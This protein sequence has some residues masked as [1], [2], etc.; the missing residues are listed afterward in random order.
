MTCD[1]CHNHCPEAHG[2]DCPCKCMDAK[3]HKYC[4]ECLE[5]TFGKYEKFENMNRYF[6]KKGKSLHENLSRINSYETDAW[7]AEQAAKL[8][9]HSCNSPV[10]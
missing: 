5:Y 8:S 6:V 9:C 3:G 2:V 1:G 4:N 7:L 10:F